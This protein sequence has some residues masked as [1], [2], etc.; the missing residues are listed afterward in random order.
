ML[1]NQR[2]GAA[3]EFAIVLPLLALILFGTIDF[4]LLFYNKQVLTNA[5][6]E[7]A[8]AAIIA[9]NWDSKDSNGFPT[10][11]ATEPVNIIKFYCLNHLV[12]LGGD[13]NLKNDPTIVDAGNFIIATVTYDYDHLFSSIIGISKTTLTGKTV[14]RQEWDDS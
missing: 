8:R 2:G 4:A 5:S 6:R 14:M 9:N 10:G 7:G 1:K 13:N 3:V 11:N 12:N